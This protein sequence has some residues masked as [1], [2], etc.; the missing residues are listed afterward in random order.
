VDVSCAFPPVPA[1]AEHIA[2]AER[3]GDC[4]AWVYATPALHLDVRMTLSR[5]S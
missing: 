5:A 1:T 2:R 4:R 3:L